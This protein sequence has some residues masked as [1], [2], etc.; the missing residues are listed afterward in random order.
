MHSTLAQSAP[1]ALTSIAKGKEL[2][3]FLDFDGTLVE[4]ADGPDEIAPI[5]GLADRLARLADRFDGRCALVSGRGI[6]N[7]EHH[8]GT[9]SIAI[10]GS[11][12]SDIRFASGKGMGQGARSLPSEIEAELRAFSH[13]HGVEYE[14]KSHGGAL[15]YRRNPEMGERAVT[16]AKELAA[17]HGWKAQ[18]GKCVIEILEKGS[19]KG[20]AVRSFM[21]DAPFAGS[22]PIFIGDDLTDEA[23]FA[24]CQELGG[25]GILVGKR[26]D[27]CAGYRLADVSSVHNWLEIE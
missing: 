18:G 20:S 8:L 3:L 16:F 27:T 6:D 1:P 21:K 24:A 13:E 23:G 12:G 2:A 5:A 9:V 26:A 17:K 4:I 25:V 10:A 22:C 15:H 7:I 11:H 14:H 19:D